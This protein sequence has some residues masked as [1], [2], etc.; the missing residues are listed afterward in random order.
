MLF[1]LLLLFTLGPLVE[2]WLLLWLMGQV[3]WS[4]TLALVLVT[5]VL[6]ASLA[7]REGLRAMSRI[8]ASL[9]QGVAPTGELVEAVLILAAG[10]V[11]ITPGMLTDVIGFCL[12]IR[13]LRRRIKDG[14]MAYFAKRIVA[15]PMDGRSFDDGGAGTGPFVDVEVTSV[16]V[17]DDDRRPET[18]D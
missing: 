10:L 13:P 9:S 7:R 6:G 11:L 4:A 12:L 8:Q 16:D 3:G 1:R 15:V 18:G 14:L 2:L 17:P 5:G